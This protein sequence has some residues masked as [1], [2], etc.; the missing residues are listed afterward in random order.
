MVLLFFVTKEIA[1]QDSQQEINFKHIS[2]KEG[3]VQSPISNFL[4]DDK[5]FIWFGNLKGLT[6]YDGYEFKTFIFDENNRKSLSSNRVNVIFQDSEKN[7]WI[8]TANGVN[9]YNREQETFTPID[10]LDIKGGRNYISSIIEDAQKNI[11]VGTYGGLKKINKKT[12]RIE[13]IVSPNQTN[14]LTTKPIFS[15]FIDKDQHIWVGTR[16]G[17]QI[18]DPQKNKLVSIPL[19]LRSDIEVANAKVLVAKQDKQGAIWFG[20][21]TSGVFAYQKNGNIL[22]KYV[23]SDKDAYS[24]A[25]NWVKDIL[26]YDDQTFWFATRN[27]LSILNTKTNKFSNYRHNPLNINSLN[28]DAIWSFMKDKASCVWIGT[29]AGGI[30][31]YYQGNSNFQNIGES[32]GNK[33]ALNHLL[34]DAVSEDKDG[35]LWVGTFGGGL[36][37]INR[38]KKTTEYY[39]L[40]SENSHQL[41]NDIKTFADDGKGNL[42][43]GSL[44]GLSL[45]NKAAKTFKHFNFPVKDGKLS[46]NLI[47]A[48]I[49]DENGAWI[50][51]NGGGLRY[52]LPDGTSKFLYRKK[53]EL[54]IKNYVTVDKEIASQFAASSSFVPNGYF[55]FLNARDPNFISDNFIQSLAKDV[56][57]NLWVGTQNGLNYFDQKTQKFTALYKKVKDTKFQI[58]NNNITTLF[59]DSKSRLWVGT[60]G[61]G[62]NYFD[63]KTKRFFAISKNLGLGD[64]VIHS[65]VEDNSENIWISTDFGLY[66]LKFKNFKTPFTKQD[67]EITGY[68]ANDGLISNQFSNNAGIRLKTNEIIFGGINGLSIFYPERIIKNKLAPK[69]AFTQILINN[70]E[71]LIDSVHSS[72]SKSEGE[73]KQIKLS[74]DQANLSFKYSALNFINPENS[75]YAYKLEGLP[76]SDEWQN[77]GKQRFV[78]FPNLAPGTYY[79]KIK[80]ANNDGVWSDYINTLKIIVLP[81]WWRTWWAYS[82]YIILLIVAAT[83]VINFLRNRARLKRDLYLEHLQNEKQEELYQMKL[84]FFTNISH[85]IR[86]PLTLILAP[87]EKILAVN[88]Q[89][90]IAKQL[91][92]IKNNADRLMK[93]VTELLDFRKA[94]EGHMKIH[95]A[96]QDIVPFCKEIFES[97]TGL[98]I[99]KNIT[100]QFEAPQHPI[101]IYFDRNQL[102]K[103]VLN[104]LSNAFKFTDVDGKI[105][106]SISPKTD[107]KN[108]LDI[109]VI[110]NG[111]GI[112]ED[113][114][115]KLFESFFQVDDGGRQNI[116]S[117][118]GLALS[119]S[120]VELHKGAI[121]VTSHASQQN[122]T[123]FTISLQT[124]KNHLKESEIV[125]ETVFTEDFKST[126]I[127]NK[128]PTLLDEDN[129]HLVKEKKYQLLLAED[130]EEVRKLIIDI[131]TDEYH[132]VDFSNGLEAMEYM[133]NEIPDL[134]ISDIM[135]PVMD[136]IEL[137][138]QVK[139]NE[140]TNHIPMI[141]LTA[142]ASTAYQVDGL[143]SGADAYISKPFSPQV[144]TLNIKN[145]LR[146]KEVMREKFSQQITLEP[147]K[148][149][150]TSPEEKFINKL[151]QIIEDK[152]GDPEFDVNELVNEIGMSRT[153]LYKKVQ[154]LTNYSVADLI[155]QMRLKKAAELFK[156]ATFPV[157]EVAYMVGFNDRKHFSKEFK[158][159]FE[160]SPSEYIQNSQQV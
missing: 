44:D 20:T 52:V 37:Y 17:L 29:F 39:S 72:Y 55:S 23:A 38:A 22:T 82:L 141:L 84:N 108:W 155:K 32:I 65:I 75:Q 149:T 137:C 132:V 136:G 74:Y 135:M 33:M 140:S 50:G 66:K 4:Q 30:N 25:S 133:K 78:N 2:Y 130:N 9:L 67:L 76:N 146:A 103:V 59:I 34:V 156:T 58:N 28:D 41:R 87:L 19:V 123:T 111:K 100:Y 3:L 154:A 129:H 10:I 93:L 88:N 12:K 54:Q 15:L 94:E 119:K 147:T 151:M 112:P 126:P 16:F 1:A 71:V 70:K 18:F 36:N 85:E 24:L 95:C 122:L 31:F 14:G 83:V 102:E 80:A 128:Q 97:F 26:I 56:D 144:L 127:L 57:G 51:T 48:I 91:D 61:G 138:N 77:T 117:G 13:D 157:A 125:S 158:K 98:A 64:D 134:I 60:E 6:R 150:I 89:S 148:I 86:T 153:V 96:Y 62:L 101:F 99:D 42:W 118:I 81:P 46:E 92:L 68:S 47:N 116:G 139:N 7:L 79:F 143:S 63:K 145:L 105:T 53:P 115:D 109:K 21:E 121:K 114:Q 40:V 131:L 73:V 49:A 45:F 11:W 27:G 159:Q 104:L 90:V 43:I 142:R 8:G 110:D 152:M 160:V 106:L 120:I 35:S 113:I 107:N 69:V 5:G 124:G